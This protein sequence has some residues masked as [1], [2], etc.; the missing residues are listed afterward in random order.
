MLSV[1][2]GCVGSVPT[3]STRLG[4]SNMLRSIKMSP[5]PL[6]LAKPVLLQGVSHHSHALK[7]IMEQLLG[8]SFRVVETS[9]KVPQPLLL[10]VETSSPSSVLCA[11]S[12]PVKCWRNNSYKLTSLKYLLFLFSSSPIC[13]FSCASVL[14]VMVKTPHIHSVDFLPLR[15]PVKSTNGI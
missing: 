9:G 11:Q 7:C 1:F 12:E 15:E 14:L 4:M 10:A 13:F 5:F 6:M 3:L 2:V 8:L